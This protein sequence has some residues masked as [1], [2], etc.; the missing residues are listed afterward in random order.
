METLVFEQIDP[1]VLGQRLQEARRAAGL[2]QQVTDD[3]SAHHGG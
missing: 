3:P 2:T 1:R